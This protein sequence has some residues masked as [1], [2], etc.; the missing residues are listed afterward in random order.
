MKKIFKIFFLTAISAGILNYA[1]AQRGR[2]SRGGGNGDRGISRAPSRSF[3]R[4]YSA[5]VRSMTS[6]SSGNVSSRQS[7]P[8]R[9]F[10]S[11]RS[12][13][14]FSNDRNITSRDNQTR[15]VYRGNTAVRT[16]QRNTTVYNTRTTIVSR[17]SYNSQRGN[18]RGGYSNRYVYHN[19]YG[20][21][22]GRRTVFMYG[23]RYRVI[24]HSFIS[25]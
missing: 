10:N 22:Y 12:E 3:S 8:E 23:T 1:Q 11:N 9:T 17:N 4:S 15:N 5:P 24:P 2:D 16:P 18:Y 21:V 19:Y 13:R 20:N 14:T 7:A 25:I 6:R